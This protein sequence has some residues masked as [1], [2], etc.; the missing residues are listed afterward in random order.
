MEAVLEEQYTDSIYACLECSG[1]GFEEWDVPIIEFSEPFSIEN[2][3]E[4]N[5]PNQ[6]K[7]LFDAEIVELIVEGSYV[8]TTQTGHC[9]YCHTLHIKC[10][11]CD[12]INSVDS[13]M[14]GVVCSG[15]GLN[16]QVDRD[17]NIYRLDN[18]TIRIVAEISDDETWF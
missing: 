3:L 10:Q 1:R 9:E 2:E 16:Y 12:T 15:C 14:P 8:T 17:D 7:L 18:E 6:L 13:E 4:Y 5:D 11:G